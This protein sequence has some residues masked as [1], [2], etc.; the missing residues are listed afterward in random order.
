VSETFR[1]NILQI[2]AAELQVIKGKAALDDN[3]RAAVGQLVAKRNELVSS[4]AIKFLAGIRP[5]TATHFYTDIQKHP[6]TS[7]SKGVN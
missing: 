5:Q 7:V 3:D 6:K 2:R 1:T 4:T